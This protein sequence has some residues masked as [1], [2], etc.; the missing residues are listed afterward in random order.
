MLDQ[1]TSR[2]KSGHRIASTL[3]YLGVLL[4]GV[5]LGLF[6][7]EWFPHASTSHTAGIAMSSSLLGLVGLLLNRS[8]NRFKN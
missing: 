8:G 2:N 4:F 6:L 7:S 1:S 5:G 3:E